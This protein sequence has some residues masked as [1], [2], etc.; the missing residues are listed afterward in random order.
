MTAEEIAAFAFREGV[1]M[2]IELDDSEA[3]DD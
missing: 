2:R 1:E 3:E